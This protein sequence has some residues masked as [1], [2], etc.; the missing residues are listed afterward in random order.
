MVERFFLAVPWG[1]LRFVIVVFSDHT[2]LLY[3]IPYTTAASHLKY[4]EKQQRK[5]ENNSRIVM[6]L[7]VSEMETKH[8]SVRLPSSSLSCLL[9]INSS[10]MDKNIESCA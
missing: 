8:I 7:F 4:V 2:H 10:Q 3:F 6:N 9:Q 1:C 5:Q